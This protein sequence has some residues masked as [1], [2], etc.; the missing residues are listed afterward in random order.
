MQIQITKITP[1]SYA[2][3]AEGFEF[4]AKANPNSGQWLIPGFVKTDYPV[5]RQ[6]TA[7]LAYNQVVQMLRQN[8]L[9]LNTKKIDG[10]TGKAIFQL[11]PKFN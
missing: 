3:K 5:L 4:H 11:N 2:F 9:Y 7:Q 8:P 1:T 10:A 6:N